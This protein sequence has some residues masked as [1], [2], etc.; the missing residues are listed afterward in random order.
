MTDTALRPATEDDVADALRTADRERGAVRVVG[1]GTSAVPARDG[2]VTLSTT[3]LTGVEDLRPDDGVVT[4]RAGTPLTVVAT[5]LAAAGRRLPL[6]HWDPTG[7]ATIGGAVAAGADGLTARE[8]FRTRDLVLGARLVTGD[9]QRV[10]VG[11][12]VVKS[13]AGFDVARMLAGSR[14]VLGVITCLDLRIETLPESDR[15][16]TCA[17][18]RAASVAEI[19]ARID[20][21]SVAPRGLV[22]TP[23]A[24]AGTCTI[25]VRYEGPSAALDAVARAPWMAEFGEIAADRR[26]TELTALASAPPPPGLVRRAARSGRDGNLARNVANR[27]DGW[28]IDVLRNRVTWIEIAPRPAESGDPHDPSAALAER[29]RRAFDPRDVLQPGRGWGAP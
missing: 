27:V 1:A 4:V 19:V 16:W 28:L 8:G 26:W 10:R 29:V 6:R 18:V 14:G 3:S 5:R 17:D 11:A 20:A 23:G 13:V 2:A 15:A 22:V 24:A 25:D 12:S 7:R 21:Y 9:G